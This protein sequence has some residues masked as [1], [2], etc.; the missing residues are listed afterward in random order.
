MNTLNHILLITPQNYYHMIQP[1]SLFNL[2]KVAI[3][4]SL[5]SN[6]LASPL[7]IYMP[8]PL[9]LLLL[10]NYLLIIYPLSILVA[11]THLITLI[12]LTSISNHLNLINHVNYFPMHIHCDSN[13]ISPHDH[14]H[15][16]TL[17]ASFSTNLYS[18]E[19]MMSSISLSFYLIN[20]SHSNPN[21][22]CFLCRL[23]LM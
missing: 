8:Y 19:A 4:V 5:L 22:I 3:L 15:M 21:C 23:M 1:L 16:P 17:L 6:H 14:L 12:H 11:N 13:L 18:L 2:E 10:S 20:R 7:A 9:H